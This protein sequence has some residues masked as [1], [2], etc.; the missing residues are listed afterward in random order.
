V[1]TQARDEEVG[2]LL[3][4]F[5]TSS[6]S[7]IREHPEHILAGANLLWIAQNLERMADHADSMCEHIIAMAT[8]YQPVPETGPAAEEAITKRRAASAAV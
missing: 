1:A 8:G 2:L 5:T 7:A 3:A 4:S 6:R